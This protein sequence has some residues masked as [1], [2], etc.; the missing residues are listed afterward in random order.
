MALMNRCTMH[1]N[2][3][4]EANRCQEHQG[5]QSFDE[6]SDDNKLI[7]HTRFKTFNLL[8]KNC[9]G[10]GSADRFDELMEELKHEE[11][12]FV[13]VNETWRTEKEKHWTTEDE[14]IFAGAGH[15]SGRKGV[16][17]LLHKRWGKNVTRFKPV[18]ER[19]CISDVKIFGV[20]YRF[21]SVYFPDSSYP[22]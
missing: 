16:G 2:P 5:G 1:G 11:W 18:S 22:D 17:I 12:D 13:M 6:I 21:V 3:N 20:A 19:I 15:D 9:R 10:L 7:L 4:S 8:V 14:H